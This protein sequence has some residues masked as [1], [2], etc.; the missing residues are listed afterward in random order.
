MSLL[1]PSS[2]INGA[3]KPLSEAENDK[4]LP[5]KAFA[6]QRFALLVGWLPVKGDA[7]NWD[8]EFQP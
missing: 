6:N 3:I 1:T 7:E 5:K 2:A 4:G 8:L